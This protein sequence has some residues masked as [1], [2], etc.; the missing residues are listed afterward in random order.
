MFGEPFCKIRRLE[1]WHTLLAAIA[2]PVVPAQTVARLVQS[3]K[4]TESTSLM[5]IPALI[6][7]HVQTAVLLKQSAKA[8]SGT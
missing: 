1:R 3:A 8:E 5:L 2:F 6:A 4:A 7:V